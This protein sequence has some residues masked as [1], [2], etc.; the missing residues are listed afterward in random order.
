M[1]PKK[2]FTQ[3]GCAR[4]IR[5]DDIPGIGPKIAAGGEF[6]VFACRAGA[7]TSR[8]FG[9]SEDLLPDYAWYAANRSNG[10][11]RPV[12]LLK[13]NDFGLFDMYGNVFE[14]CHEQFED[15]DRATGAMGS[16]IL[17][18][19]AG[20]FAVALRSAARDLYAVAVLEPQVSPNCGFR[21]AR[22]LRRNPKVGG[23]K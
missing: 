16:H 13:P 3:K 12:G 7:W 18:G 21:I 23:S 5:P 4:S 1:S 20:D 10:R 17:G 11:P 19:G 2:Q 14:W 9:A 22:T 6:D 15:K 8:Y